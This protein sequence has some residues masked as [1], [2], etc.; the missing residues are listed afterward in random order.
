MASVMTV[1]GLALA[2]A[3][4]QPGMVATGTRTELV[5]NKT[6]MGKSPMRPADS[7]SRTARPMSRLSQEKASPD[8]DRDGHGGDGGGRA[9]V[10]PESDRGPDPDHQQ[11]DEQI[12]QGVGG[13][14]AGQHRAAGDGQR[15]EPVDHAGVQVLGDGHAGLGRVEPDREHEEPRQQVVDVAAPLWHA[16]RAAEGVGEQQHEQH[17]LHGGEDQEGGHASQPA[18]VPQGDGG[19]AGNR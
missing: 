6:M 19:G 16:D 11:D 18:Q 2:K 15:A 4:S 10:E 7:E 14:T 8:G 12:A 5:K 9:G 3:W 1:S 13:D 17:R